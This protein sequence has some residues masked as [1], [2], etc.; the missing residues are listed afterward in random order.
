[1]ADERA[2]AYAEWLVANE[3][4]RGTPE[5]DTVVEA[6]KA[7]R[8]GA[9][10]AAPQSAPKAPPGPDVDSTWGTYAGNLARQ[11]AQG[12]SFN[13]GDEIAAG[14]RSLF[15]DETYDQALADE[16]AKIEEFARRNP[17]ASLTA[18]FGGALAGGLGAGL[19]VRGAAKAGNALAGRALGWGTSNPI[20][21][22][23]TAGTASGAVGGFGEGEGTDTEDGLGNRL[24]GALKGGV[25]GAGLG[26]V[27]GAASAAIP[28]VT[29]AF[30]Q[31]VTKDE[32]AVRQAAERE[33]AKA[34]TRSGKT[35]EQLV[36]RATEDAGLGV[37]SALMNAD[38]ELTKLGEIVVG[39]GG[40]GAKSLEDTVK[41]QRANAPQRTIGNLE[42]GITDADFYGSQDDILRQLRET[43]RQHY[44][45]APWMSEE[46]TD[47]RILKFLD[48]SYGR[49]AFNRAR[50]IIE[51]E[52]LALEMEGKDASHL[53]LKDLFEFE[54]DGVT[55]K[56]IREGVRPD[57]RTLDLVRRG[58][59]DAVDSGFKGDSSIGKAQAGALADVEKVYS[60]SLDDLSEGY[61]AARAKYRGD[62]EV[63]DALEMGQKDFLQM[64]PD[65][66]QR[67]LKGMSEA[68]LEAFRVGAMK[69]IR[70]RVFGAVDNADPTKK[71]GQNVA[72]MREKLKMLVGDEQKADLMMAALQ[73]EAEVIKQGQ[74]IRGQGQSR[75]PRLG[76]GIK[77]FDGN[78]AADVIGD[79]ASLALNPSP[80]N[81]LA[82]AM[83]W[84]GRK[85]FRM[86]E[87]KAD[88]VAKILRN[89]TPQEIE[90]VMKRLA[91][92]SAADSAARETVSG[93]AALYGGAPSGALSAEIG[94]QDQL[95]ANRGRDPSLPGYKTGG[96]VEV[97]RDFVQELSG[98]IMRHFASGGKVG[99]A[100]SGGLD[101]I[102]RLKAGE[103]APELAQRYPALKNPIEEF[104]E[105]TGKQFWAK[106]LSEEGLAVQAA[107]KQA[108]RSIDMG[109]Y[110][111][112]FD[113]NAR[114]DVDP[115]NYPTSVN[116][117]VDTLPKK[118]DTIEKHRAIADTPEARERIMRAYDVGMEQPGAPNW[119][120]MRQLE[121]EFVKRL[122]PEAGRAAFQKQF[123]RAMSATT[124]GADPTS[125]LMM[126]QYG[127][128]L[129]AGGQRIPRNRPIGNR[130]LGAEG[131]PAT[132][133]FPFPVG[134]R[135]AGGNM[136]MY[137]KAMID[138]MP[139]G[140]D[141]PKRHNFEHN[142]LGHRN[143]ATM[144]EQMSNL[145]VP[146]Q[147]IPK[148][149]GAWEQVV[150]D[151][152]AKAGV[153]PR[154]MQEVAWAGAKKLKDGDKYT[155]KPMIQIVN[156]AVERTRRITGLSNQEIMDG[157]VRGTI[158][159]YRRG[160]LATLRDRTRSSMSSGT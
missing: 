26:T 3:D 124:G 24:E 153:D 56:G 60:R 35:P 138:G 84:I 27:A 97:P 65:G 41:A 62:A 51:K 117:V 130:F 81:A 112:M 106:D 36:G 95:S 114:T 113:V 57:M 53:V 18:N 105:K 38:D 31:Y 139:L 101:I 61:K 63:R 79:A 68:E 45:N 1:M 10:A 116:T 55:I 158:P 98:H 30:K 152:A 19:A 146:G 143:M 21:A 5:F 126:A 48:S 9:P 151:Q 135:Y 155:P 123:A 71:A 120:F 147:N 141:N 128:V 14:A 92:R 67:A 148:N 40:A 12:L 129:N 144:D 82:K 50:S 159:L 42:K 107:R 44:D 99:K 119:Y 90:A 34:I 75:T 142:F 11:A 13:F 140:V 59:R 127:N 58:L 37:P 83:D 49:D 80:Q 100:V 32:D 88:E 96:P 70:D 131:T 121:D 52:K 16:R 149:Y 73:R 2:R 74:Q 25:L 39:K 87:L 109:E 64:D 104:D 7:A 111:P 145:I 93:R 78:P 122:G 4:K 33:V 29:K 23:A 102:R 156:E 20:K 154:F 85:D 69:T 94:G 133:D 150:H 72:Y 91:E 103:G 6:Y 17:G 137:E 15:G 115:T 77:D 46:V 43:G 8:A 136:E 157:I 47:P 160:G 125:N 66:M 54:P 89:G 110:D 76:E 118:A 86:T 134:G 132:Y 28:G 108:Q 22:G